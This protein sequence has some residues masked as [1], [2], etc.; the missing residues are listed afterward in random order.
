MTAEPLPIEVRLTSAVSYRFDRTPRLRVRFHAFSE[1]IRARP[2]ASDGEVVDGVIRYRV[3]GA[4]VWAYVFGMDRGKLV[5][6]VLSVD[7]FNEP[8]FSE[9]VYAALRAALRGAVPYAANV[10]TAADAY[11]NP[12]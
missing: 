12:R 9:R 11:R 2:V 4:Y 6:S 1:R 7:A 5:V 3:D 10:E 8:T